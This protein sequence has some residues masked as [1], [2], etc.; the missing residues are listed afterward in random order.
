VLL[1]NVK[2]NQTNK[3]G[4]RIGK[5]IQF[6]L[7]YPN[8]C[9]PLNISLACGDGFH[10]Y[11]TTYLKYRPLKDNEYNGSMQRI[12]EK[13]DTINEELY[14]KTEYIEVRCKIQPGFF[15]I[16]GEGEYRNGLKH[17]KWKYFYSSG[18]LKK[19]IEYRKEKPISNYKIYREDGSV[20]IELNKKK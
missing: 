9:V 13:I 6:E 19:N 7:C 14:Y 18:I 12:S 5:W 4:K 3:S 10:E 16:L 2:Y 20:M 1:N 15:C 17:G 11:R 8:N